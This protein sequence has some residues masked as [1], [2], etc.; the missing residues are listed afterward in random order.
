MAEQAQMMGLMQDKLGRCEARLENI[1]GDLRQIRRLLEQ[2][3][4]RTT[5]GEIVRG[6]KLRGVIPQDFDAAKL[7]EVA[8][9]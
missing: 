1:G 2:R 3:A 7:E 4:E 9:A 8:G 6:L 5:F